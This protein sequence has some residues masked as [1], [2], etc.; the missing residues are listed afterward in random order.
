MIV[1][2]S[3]LVHLFDL[4]DPAHVAKELRMTRI[5]PVPIPDEYGNVMGLAFPERG[6]LLGFDLRD[7]E[8][9]VSKIQLEPLTA[10]PFVLRA[11]YDFERRYDR[12]LADLDLA[13]QLNPQY[14]R[15]SRVTCPPACRIVG[16]GKDAL[17]SVEHAI[18]LEEE[19]AEYQLLR[20]TILMQLGKL[21]AAARQLERIIQP[22][23]L[24]AYVQA[25]IELLRGDLLS[26]ETPGEF[27]EAIRHHLKAIELAVPLANHAEFVPRRAAKK[28]LI[29]AHLAVARDISLGNFQRQHEVAPRWVQR[30]DSLANEFIRRDQGDPALQLLIAYHHLAVA[31]D[32]RNP[33]DPG[34]I[35]DEAVTLSRKRIAGNDDETNRH[36]WEWLLGTT[37]A[38]AT[39]L[40][41]I[42]GQFEEA[43]EAANDALGLF[44]S[45]APHR[46]STPDQK[47]LV[48]RLYF[49]IGSL[50]A[51]QH[52]DHEEAVSW[53]HKA[54][55]MLS[56]AAPSPMLSDLRTHGESFVSM[57][58][59]YWEIGDQE[60]AIELTELGTDVLQKA[61]AEDWLSSE[62]LAIPYGNLASMHQTAGHDAEAKAFAELAATLDGTVDRR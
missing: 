48:G 45:S 21:S 50:H 42:R 39:R 24:P 40:Q 6:V 56:V 58:V 11:D 13:L 54:E 5:E 37:L 33:D 26:Q 59:S 23:D 62:V 3:I 31:A 32:L 25:E 46:Q 52:K 36:R 16:R 20:A 55:P 41:R 44:Q 28:T 61:V 30:A 49:H 22:R 12:N 17:E 27:N 10:E 4:Q 47:F 57:G 18:E 15:A 38:E 60:R 19:N 35:V 8:S 43:I 51:V 53:Y 29:L 14:A 2:R 1:S 9:L 34:H 7:P